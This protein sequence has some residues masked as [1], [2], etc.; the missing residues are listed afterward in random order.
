MS[1]AAR[2]RLL[3]AL[4]L[5]AATRPTAAQTPAVLST[6]IKVYLV[7]T[8]HFDSSPSDVHRT[9][10]VDMSPPERQRQLEELTDKLQKTQA[11]KVFIEWQPG[12]QRA[13]DSTYALYRQGRFELGNSERY[14]IGYRLA[15]KLNR[16]RV[17][18]T[19]T[20]PK[21]T[22]STTTKRPSSKAR[23]KRL[24]LATAWGYYWRRARPPSKR[25][26]PLRLGQKIV[27]CYPCSRC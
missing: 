8:Y 18:S 19:L 11:D 16:T 9:R 7:G 25:A 20:P 6:K 26:K 12:Q 27:S 17:S 22:R 13:T 5:L 10:R 2:F 4:V 24:R 3:L 15:K 1:Y 21:P 23:T 14:Q